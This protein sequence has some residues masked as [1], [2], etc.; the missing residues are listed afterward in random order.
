[1]KSYHTKGEWAIIIAAG[2]LLGLLMSWLEN[3]RDMQRLLVD[4]K[5]K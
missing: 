5:I 1:M 3:Y 2:I 4:L